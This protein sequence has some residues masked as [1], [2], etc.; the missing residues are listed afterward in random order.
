MSAQRLAVAAVAALCLGGCATFPEAF[1]FTP[2]QP[3][4]PADE[5]AWAQARDRFTASAKLYDGLATRAFV[6]A[7]YQSPDVRE[8]RVARMAVWREVGAEERDRLLQLERDEASQYEDFIVSLFTPDRS[9]NDLDSNRSV[10]RLAVTVAGEG[11]EEPLKVEAVRSDATVRTLYP[12]IGD[13]DV[14]YRVRFARWP[15]GPLEQR[16]FALR[17]AGA[18]GRMD[19]AF[20]APEKK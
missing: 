11:E 8:R 12:S 13:F 14:V 5:G 15:K 2:A 10:W 18:R 20:P 4:P 16:Q 7:V 9:D 6:S 17:I 3:K 1:P 19:L